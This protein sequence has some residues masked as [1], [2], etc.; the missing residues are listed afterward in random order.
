MVD[1]LDAIAGPVEGLHVVQVPLHPLERQPF[2]GA[3]LAR[4]SN[5]RPD[6]IA[7]VE[8]GPNQVRAELAGRPENKNP[9]KS[10]VMNAE[11]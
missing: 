9:H 10:S 1:N 5:Q 2:Q 7:L 3:C 4:C 8:Q 11:R 6:L